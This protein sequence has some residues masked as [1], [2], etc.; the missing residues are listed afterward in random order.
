MPKK[1]LEKLSKI[2]RKSVLMSIGVSLNFETSS[3]LVDYKNPLNLITYLSK[4][5]LDVLYS[6]TF[7]RNYKDK[8]KHL[9]IFIVK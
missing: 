6:E 4:N 8:A 9:D 3:Y 1:S 5:S 7:K 2:I